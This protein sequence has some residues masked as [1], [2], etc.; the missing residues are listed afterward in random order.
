MRIEAYNAVS[1]VYSAKKPTKVS[2][3]YSSSGVDQVQISSIGKDIQ[4][5]K[6]A[7]ANAPDVRKEVT[8]PIK[9]AINNGTYSVSNDD[10][11]S[12]LLAKYE[13]KLSF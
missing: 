2:K 12:K 13:E 1:Q 10:F 6:Q 3:S 7:V 5:L 8:E 4:T 11:A 9:A